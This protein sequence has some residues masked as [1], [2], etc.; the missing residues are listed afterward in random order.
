M[1]GGY[2][3]ETM[4]QRLQRGDAVSPERDAAQELKLIESEQIPLS[5]A[6]QGVMSVPEIN[7]TLPPVSSGEE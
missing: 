7:S 2:S 3:Y 4:Y 5:P 1:K 6:E